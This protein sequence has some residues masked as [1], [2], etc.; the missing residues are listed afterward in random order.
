M[1]LQSTISPHGR[2][3]PRAAILDFDGTLADTKGLILG[4]MHASLA[5]RRLPDPGDDVCASTIGLPLVEGFKRLVP[6]N[7]AALAE[8]CAAIYRRLFTERNRPGLIN[9]FPHVVETLRALH[10]RGIILSVAS[11]RHHE[12]LANYIREFGL[13]GVFSLVLGVDDVGRAKP[14]PQPVCLTLRSLGL[15]PSEAVVVGDTSF[16]ILMGRRAGCL[17]VGVTYG[18]GSREELQEAGADILLDDFAGLAD[19]CKA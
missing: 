19:L 1:H 17:T 8:E 14:D 18:N 6:E 16:D 15:R 7:D 3:V 4:I 11:S 13:D 12:S 9:P 5:E 10:A 2:P